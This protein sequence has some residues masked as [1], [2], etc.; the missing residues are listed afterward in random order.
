M[1]NPLTTKDVRRHSLR[2]AHAATRL[3]LLAIA[4]VLAGCLPSGQPDTGTLPR[5]VEIAL[6]TPTH[7]DLLYGTTPVAYER[8]TR[9]RGNILSTDADTIHLRVTELFFLQGPTLQV[10]SRTGAP[11]ATVILDR[12]PRAAP[13]RHY[14][15][16]IGESLA[17][18]LLVLRIAVLLGHGAS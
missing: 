10:A 8:V 16:N 15:G 17:E 6:D 9:L 2:P 3:L 14:D 12:R 1:R 18:L 7:V 13:V 11:L 4:L 5:R